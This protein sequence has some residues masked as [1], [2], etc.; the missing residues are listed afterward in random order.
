MLHIFDGKNKRMM[1]AGIFIL[2]VLLA[3]FFYPKNVLYE[4]D[5]S[6][7]NLLISQE[8]NVLEIGNINV[9]VD[10]ADTPAL[11]ERGLSGR[12]SLADNEGMF[13][14]F[15]RPDRYAFWMNEMNFPIDIIWIGEDWKVADITDT[16]TPESFPQT[17]APKVPARYV[18]EVQAGFA[19][20]NGIKMGDPISFVRRSE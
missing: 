16:A 2:V 14:I 6:G 13:F 9:H 15:E 3:I 8:N 12:A 19:A 4:N 1:F 7:Q 5:N 17:F 18:L 11:R 10:I 20:R